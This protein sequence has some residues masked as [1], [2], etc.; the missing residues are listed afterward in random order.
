MNERRDEDVRIE[1]EPG[2]LF[3]ALLAPIGMNLVVCETHRLFFGEIE[4]RSDPRQERGQRRLPQGF[5]HKLGDGTPR[6]AAATRISRRT[7]SSTYIVVLT[8]ARSPHLASMPL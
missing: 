7:S 8:F 4:P 2:Q 5:F 1:D 3:A 6:R